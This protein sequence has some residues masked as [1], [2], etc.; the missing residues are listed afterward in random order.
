M[1]GGL[2]EVGTWLSPR[3]R[4]SRQARCSRQ[5][6]PT[7]LL[8]GGS[9]RRGRVGI[10]GWEGGNCVIFEKAET[11]LPRVEERSPSGLWPGQ[12]KSP[13]PPAV[14]A[15]PRRVHGLT[16]LQG[17]TYRLIGRPFKMAAVVKPQAERNV[18]AP[19]TH[20]L[21]LPRFPAP[22]AMLPVGAG[23]PCRA[24]PWAY[25]SNSPSS[26]QHTLI[27]VVGCQALLWAQRDKAVLYFTVTHRCLGTFRVVSG[28]GKGHAGAR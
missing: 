16:L 26:N 17:V 25:P 22:A 24:P 21:H 15:T 12:A 6:P 3:S 11:A 10:C 20:R 2:R 7:L 28:A 23:Q 1:I 4:R 8:T 5:H 14:A 9:G 19:H 18:G 27:S 13:A